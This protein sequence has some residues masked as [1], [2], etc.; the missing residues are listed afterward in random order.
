MGNVY[1][2]YYCPYPLMN[3]PCVFMGCLFLAFRVVPPEDEVELILDE[4]LP[5]INFLGINVF[6]TVVPCAFG[7]ASPFLDL[8]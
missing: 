3:D 4:E 1:Y 6:G 7:G 2:Y 8:M 5:L